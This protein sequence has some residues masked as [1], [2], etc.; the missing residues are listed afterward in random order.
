MLWDQYNSEA[1]QCGVGLSIA[2]CWNEELKDKGLMGNV[3]YNAK[4][5]NKV[6]K[7]K[8]TLTKHLYTVHTLANKNTKIM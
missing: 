1:M 5:F 4:D 8:H 7:L 6:Q 2:W 3:Q